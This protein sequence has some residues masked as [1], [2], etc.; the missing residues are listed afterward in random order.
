MKRKTHIEESSSD[1]QSSKQVLENKL[2]K[3]SNEEKVEGKQ[4]IWNQITREQFISAVKE[5]GSD[6]KQLDKEIWRFNE[7]T[8]SKDSIWGRLISKLKL[9]Q[10]EIV[11]HSLYNVCRRNRQKIENDMSE[12]RLDA[13][14]EN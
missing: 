2:D 13:V 5:L 8:R 4:T 9:N 6:K 10:A 7:F 14:G 11:R 1:D 12:T 3:Q